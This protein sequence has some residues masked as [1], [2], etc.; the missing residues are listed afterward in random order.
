VLSGREQIKRVLADP[1]ERPVRA[2]ARCLVVGVVIALVAAV[3]Q[4][5]TGFFERAAPG[6]FLLIGLTMSFTLWGADRLWFGMIAPIFHRPFSIPAYISRLPFW[7]VAGGI[8][9]EAAV[10]C[11]VSLD[12]IATY[13][14]A[15]KYDFDLGARLGV[16]SA[17]LLQLALYQTVQQII[18]GPQSHP[19]AATMTRE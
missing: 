18:R 16:F 8:A 7:Y 12:W 1:R 10:L 11:S 4:L 17:G 19:R 2:L 3:V 13:G 6:A 14:I 9:F 5:F 15:V